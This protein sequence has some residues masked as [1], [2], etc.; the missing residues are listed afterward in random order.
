MA[1]YAIAGNGRADLR[2]QLAKAMFSSAVAVD[3][4]A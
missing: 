3:A 4:I 1:I 2:G